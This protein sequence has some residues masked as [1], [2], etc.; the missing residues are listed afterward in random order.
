MKYATQNT[1][2]G[3][4]I[5]GMLLDTEKQYSAY[6]IKFNPFIKKL[7]DNGNGVL[8][9]GVIYLRKLLKLLRTM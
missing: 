4:S 1:P 2:G 8:P 5:Y 6:K 9:D 7:I 3:R